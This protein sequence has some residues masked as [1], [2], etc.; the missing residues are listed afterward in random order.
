MS[1]NPEFIPDPKSSTTPDVCTR[2]MRNPDYKGRRASI[3]AMKKRAG[4]AG[5]EVK[6]VRS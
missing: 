1:K 5:F 3:A 6:L 4:S 2:M